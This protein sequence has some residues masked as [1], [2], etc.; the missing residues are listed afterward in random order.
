MHDCKRTVS[1]L[2]DL[3]LAETQPEAQKQLLAELR[4]CEACREEF[5]TLRSTLRISDQALR[6][7]LPVESFW[8]GYHERLR[9]RLAAES[10]KQ[11]VHPS[12]P[13][14]VWN[15]LRRLAASSV[16]LPVPAAAAFVL[17]LGLSI[18]FALHA[19]G[20]AVNSP[21]AP[22]TV[23]EIKTVEVPVVH[24]KVITRV[25][26]IERTRHRGETAAD[27]LA[28]SQSP[29]TGAEAA[30]SKALSLIGFKPT[31]QVKLKVIKGSYRDEK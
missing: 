11:V 19:R 16:R 5:T 9:Q 30:G 10:T 28:R 23:V 22:A 14:L 24:E 17:V 15:A 27:P 18:F 29:Q 26:Y 3:A 13:V 2:I 7:A 6:S 21:A 25:V 20:Q 31:D 12:G 4:D 1:V 8:P